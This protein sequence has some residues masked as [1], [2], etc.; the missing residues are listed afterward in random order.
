MKLMKDQKPNAANR[1]LDPLD[2]DYEKR[3]VLLARAETGYVQL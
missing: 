3:G 1:K 2:E